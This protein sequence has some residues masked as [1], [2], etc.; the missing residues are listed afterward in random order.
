MAAAKP[1]FGGAMSPFMSEIINKRVARN[2]Y[3]NA[4]AILGKDVNYPSV[5]SWVTRRDGCVRLPTVCIMASSSDSARIR[6]SWPKYSIA[7]QDRNS[8]MH[9]Q[10]DILV[11]EV[12]LSL[13]ELAL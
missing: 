3:F 13:R 9:N 11:I 1:L 8:L 5:L 6:F 10:S 2:N 4:P 7:H 12:N